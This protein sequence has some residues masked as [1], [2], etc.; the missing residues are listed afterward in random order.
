MRGGASV[1]RM[2]VVPDGTGAQGRLAL[3]HVHA[4]VGTRRHAVTSN[5]AKKKWDALHAAYAKASEAADE[6][7]RQLH[8]KY[9]WPSNEHQW[10]TWLKRG[11]RDK[12]ERLE[13]RARAAGD[14]IIDFVVQVSP[15]GESWLHG[16]LLEHAAQEL[17]ATHVLFVDEEIHV[18]FPRRDGT[19]EKAEVWQKDGYW[20]AQGPGARTI[21]QKPPSNAQSIAKRIHRSGARATTRETSRVARHPIVRVVITKAGNQCTMIAYD[22]RGWQRSGWTTPT[23]CTWIEQKAEEWFPGVPIER[24]NARAVRDRPWAQKRNTGAR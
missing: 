8:Q 2:L 22:D 9:A 15:R 14:K 16:D 24:V 21:V 20:H 10:H 12:I 11:E 7:E 3:L 5:A 13:E 6:Y 17:G 4:R 1:P 23:D 19:Y 18:Y